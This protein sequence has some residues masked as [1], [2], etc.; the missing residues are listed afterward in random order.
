M[1]KYKPN[2]WGRSVYGICVFTNISIVT[3][4][5]LS[6]R[7]NKCG[8]LKTMYLGEAICSW[9]FAHS[10]M[11]FVTRKSGICF[12]FIICQLKHVTLTTINV[13]LH[14]GSYDES[15]IKITHG[16]WLYVVYKEKKGSVSLF[17]L[18][19][20][21]K[22]EAKSAIIHTRVINPVGDYKRSFKCKWCNLHFRKAGRD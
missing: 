17:I 20:S 4:K 22:N 18:K 7:E 8:I 9:K 19:K 11:T 21:V 15:R 13:V 10:H 14:N 16:Q 6:V 12:L 2:K 3:V 5:K 1:R